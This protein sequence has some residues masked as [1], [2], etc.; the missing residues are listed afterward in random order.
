MKRPLIVNLCAGPGAG[1]STLAAYTF[2]YLKGNK[3]CT[4]E[5]S[6]EIAKEWVYASRIPS[7]RDQTY[8]FA[9]QAHRLFN[10][11]NNVEHT[12][13]VIITDCPLF[14][15]LI[16]GINQPD[17]FTDLVWDTFDKYDNLVC[18]V[19]REKDYIQKGRFQTETQA[20]E[21]DTEV[22]DLLELNNIAYVKVPGNLNESVVELIKLRL[23]NGN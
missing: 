6:L 19:T 23:K 8:L 22:L 7:F 15:S 4:A 16:Y 14:L 1:K 12:P 9:K 11:A 21:K 2:A 13:D 10:L 17:S 5:L 18:Y 3:I 20:H